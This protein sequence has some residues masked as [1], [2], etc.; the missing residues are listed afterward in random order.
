VVRF[1]PFH[2]DPAQGLTLGARSV[3]L[4]PKSLTL[5]SLLARRA[6][7]VVTKA[8]IFAAVWPD[9]AVSDAALTSC[10]QELRTALGDDARQPRYIE[11]VHRRGFRFVAN[12]VP[13]ETRPAPPVDAA[14]AAV[15]GRDAV[16][17]SMSEAMTRARN[18]RRQVVLVTG[19][20]GIGKSAVVNAFLQSA[21]VADASVTGAGC[22]EQHGPTEV[23]GALLEA[24]TR[25]ARTPDG[26]RVVATLAQ[27]A[28]TWLAHM[29]AV[30][31][32][33]QYAD[34]QR[35]TAG[36]TRDRMLR[37][38]NDAIDQLASA[39]PLLIWLEDLHWA[40]TATLDWLG[41]FAARS[42][43][44]RVLFIGTCRRRELH[45][46]GDAIDDVGSELRLKGLC[47][48]LALTGLD[49]ASFTALVLG[50]Y[51]PAG[52][53]RSLARLAQQVWSRTDG[54]PLF[55]M[56][57]L[58]DLAARGVLVE[59]EGRWHAADDSD[60][61][62]FALPDDVRRVIERQHERLAP[63]HLETLEAASIVGLESSAAAVAAALGTDVAD[64]EARLAS[65]ARQ[66]R[67]IV[68]AGADTWPDGSVSGRFRFA[69]SL[70]REVL[71]ARIPARRRAELHRRVGL[72]LEMA[73]GD[74]AADLATDLAAHFE[75]GGE[76]QRAVVYLRHAAATA[77]R[78]SATLQAAGMFAKALE[79]LTKLPPSAERDELEIALRVGRGAV[80]MA[81]KGWGAPEAEDMYARARELS[82]G[83]GDT[84]QLFRAT[85]GLWLFYWGRG[86]MDAAT[87][88][89]DRLLAM[90]ARGGDR[91]LLLQAHHALWATSFSKGDIRSAHEH[92][93]S[94]SALY[95]QERH[96]A[97]VAAYGNHDAAVCAHAF[98]ARALAMLGRD[99]DSVRAADAGI[100]LA[101]RLGHPF[102][103][104]LAL[105]FAAAVHQFRA[106]P[107]E[108]LRH[109]AEAAALAREHSFPLL[110]AWALTFEGWAEVHAGRADHGTS[111][112]TEG[113]D[114]AEATGSDQ[115][116]PH[117]LG[118]AADA[119][120]RA[121]R[122]AEARR[123]VDR[124]LEL[125]AH[126]GER[127]YESELHRLD[128][129]L[130]LKASGDRRG[131]EE[132]LNRALAVASG[133]GAILFAERS[134]ARL[135]DLKALRD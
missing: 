90:A 56:N 130:R 20:P 25:L 76:L 102:S 104:A 6:G 12:V 19:P 106:A 69:H 53:G 134:E 47:Q 93:S 64:V 118:V 115:F 113:L 122:L 120:L 7:L 124:A 9:T 14:V 88:L 91:E 37:E 80:L 126:T 82:E 87:G 36:T 79:L 44:A 72:R 5:L 62:V 100:A 26:P 105:V 27:C 1:G 110:L 96:F 101:R 135:R 108:A 98:D 89:A 85:W 45:P 3:H 121:G 63:D 103:L 51:P 52:A 50:R 119:H 30:Q 4:T 99:G 38:L 32:P 114:R 97:L 127:F 34:L 83:F 94:G 43:P 128:A 16:L 112:I 75:R 8:E 70:Y 125:A 84:P 28:P 65:M 24:L 107:S 29:P 10:I 92:A 31:S 21:V 15:V 18:G 109:A 95:V 35:R 57:V 33:A 17:A 71:Y 23:Y 42:D 133:Q 117:L 11:T 77:V 131:A 58:A 13:P 60:S 2:L 74:R 123:S 68:E 40:D 39:I 111:L 78:R 41:A 54:N 66:T 48:E 46:G 22:V 61:P 49:E 59:R 55:G 116:R 73:F 67:F 129:E 132:A 86:S 81:V